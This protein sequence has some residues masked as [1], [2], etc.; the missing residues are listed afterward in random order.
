MKLLKLYCNDER[1]KTVIFKA[2]LNLVIAK[3]TNP[4]NMDKDAHNLGK[5]KLIELID[6]MF[7]KKLGKESFLKNP[8]FNNH[9]FYLEIQLYNNET[10][11]IRRS[12][13]ENTK[14]SFKLSKSKYNDF[15]NEVIWDYNKLPLSSTDPTR[16]PKIILNSLL[17]F[18]VLKNY[19]YR[20]SLNY[21][22]RTQS[23]YN[24]VFKLSKFVASVDWKPLLFEL[25]G[26]DPKFVKDKFLLDKSLEADKDYYNKY[27][28]NENLDESDYNRLKGILEIKENE[29]INIQNNLN[30]I[31]FFE[32]DN[33]NIKNLVES[34]DK[35]ISALNSE[36]YYLERDIETLSESI[37]TEFS[38]N[39]KDVTKLYTEINLYFSEELKKSYDDL[40]EFNKLITKDRNKTITETISDKKIKLSK[41]KDNLKLC[42]SERSSYLKNIL[43]N[44]L[45]D[46]Y[47]VVQEE[48]INIEKEIEVLNFKLERFSTLKELKNNI[49]NVTMDI[50]NLVAKI[51]L[52]LETDNKTFTSI[53]THFSNFVNKI[54]NKKGLISISQNTNGNIEFKDEILGISEESTSENNGF[55][56]KKILCACFDLSLLIEYSQKMYSYFSFV[57]HDG[58]LE[59]LDPRK[60]ENYLN[61]AVKICENNP[62]QYIITLIESDIPKEFYNTYKLNDSI[63]TAVTLSDEDES[64]TLFGFYF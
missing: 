18:N 21:F 22:L 46:K 23:D 28:I 45:Y 4:N 17:N 20:Q 49:D 32:F 56:Y 35:N 13:K 19:D 60:Q 39:M 29:K 15:R 5:S 14:I 47:K 54:I 27:K 59:S 44:N 34:I 37:E 48:L 25:L 31:D 3:I 8:I 62:I 24:N 63:N 53:R 64:G 1:F 61:L 41:L 42:N 10:L 2:G 50:K 7:L 58:C 26:Y 12:V 6:F 52:Q 38:F 57:V 40:I 36:I 30:K 55:S 51:E 33:S 43:N 11:T 9:I 16:S